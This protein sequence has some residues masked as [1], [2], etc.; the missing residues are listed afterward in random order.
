MLKHRIE[1]RTITSLGLS[2]GTGLAL[3]TLFDIAVYDANRKAPPKVDPSTYTTHIFN[4]YTLFRNVVSSIKYKEKD[5][6]IGQQQVKEQLLNDMYVLT[7]LYNQSDAKLAFYLPN[8]SSMYER[9]NKGKADGGYKP[10]ALHSLMVSALKGAVYPG[11]VYVGNTNT[12][13]PRITGKS[14]LL[15]HHTLDLLNAVD[16]N[17]MHLLESHTGRVKSKLEWGTKYHPIGKR[18]LTI[19]PMNKRLLYIL[20][21]RTI[22]KPSTLLD[23]VAIY[24]IALARKWNPTT[25]A[26]VINTHI[27]KFNP[28]I[29]V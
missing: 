28:K 10:Y 26:S 6:L 4:I 9:M 13:L 29:P 15:S 27:K 21:D 25:S 2:I 22:V 8:Y 3:E 17:T 5:L 23:R 24:D 7:T 14:L 19:L 1:D 20:G 16:G 11:D 12:G 18:D